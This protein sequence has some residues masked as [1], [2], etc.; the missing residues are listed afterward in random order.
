MTDAATRQQQLLTSASKYLAG[1]GLG[2]FVLPADLNLVVAQK[3]N[4]TVGGD[5]QEKIQGLRK[6]VAVISQ[7]L[8]A[9]KNWI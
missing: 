4:A 6:S 8:Q 5:M 3:H 1:G 7:Q 2:L 9:P